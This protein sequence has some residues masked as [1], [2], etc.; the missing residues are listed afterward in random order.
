MIY[1]SVRT[2]TVFYVSLLLILVA[3]VSTGSSY[4]FVRSTVTDLEKKSHNNILNLLYLFAEAKHEQMQD[5]KNSTIT[6]IHKQGNSLAVLGY[7]IIF[8]FY[9]T[10]LSGQFSEDTARYVAYRL[11]NTID[12]DNAALI[13]LDENG[14]VVATGDTQFEG[15]VIQGIE[16]QLKRAKKNRVN[17]IIDLGTRLHSNIIYHSGWNLW[18]CSVIDMSVA[19]MHAERQKKTVADALQK[20]FVHL[21]IAETGKAYLTKPGSP[22]DRPAGQDEFRQSRDFAPLDWKIT[23]TAPVREIQKPARRLA[24]WQ[25]III[26]AGFVFAVGLIAVLI[27]RIAKPLVQLADCAKILPETDFIPNDFMPESLL[28]QQDEVGELSRSFKF[29]Q[30]ELNT[31]VGNLKQEKKRIRILHRELITTQERERRK[32]SL[33]LHDG[34]IQELTGAKHGY[35]ALTVQYPEMGGDIGRCNEILSESISCLRNLS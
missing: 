27:S 21:R 11:I 18:V 1:R 32:I 15:V 2:K 26:A 23:V 30:T 24:K 22:P 14:R 17:A 34:V 7:N 33:D 31:L 35:N 8:A 3:V 5:T 25:G 9:D 28:K 10:Q 12:L 13:L 6:A 16:G 20:T 19:D 4:L 29:M